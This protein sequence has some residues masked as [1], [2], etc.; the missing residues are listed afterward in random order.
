LW[1]AGK[2]VDAEVAESH[3]T[4]ESDAPAWLGLLMIE[5]GEE[6][7]LEE[8]N[9]DHEEATRLMGLS[10]ANH[11]LARQSQSDEALTELIQKHPNSATRIAQTLAYRGEF[12]EA[13]K[14]VEKAYTAHEEA[15]LWVKVHVGLRN[16]PQ[17][18]A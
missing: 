14:W 6:G 8:I 3:L 17:M 18:H 9:R 11:R 4:V 16:L 2:L 1:A 13:F 7:G 5:R 15:L 10:M 12:D